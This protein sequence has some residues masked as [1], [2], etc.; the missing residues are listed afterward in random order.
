MPS[1]RPMRWLEAMSRHRATITAAPNFA[2]DLCVE[3]STPRSVRRSICRTGRRPCV[4]RSRCVARPW[5]RFA[6]AFAP[7]GFR[8]EAFHPVYGTGGGDAAGLG[9][10]RTPPYPVVR[11]MDRV[12][13]R[14]HRV[15]DVAPEHPSA[16]AFVGCGRPQGGQE[17][18]IVDP[19]T[20][21]PCGADEVG[22]IWV[23][24]P[25]VA[26][27]YWGRPEQTEEAFSASHLRRLGAARSSVPGTWDSF[28]RASCSSRDAARTSSS[29]AAATTTPRTSS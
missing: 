15:V 23:A 20:R 26:Q 8:P 16:A 14:E 29:S 6:D 24:G 7:A 22:E 10:R 5:R 19:E 17:V 28:A 13:L 4:A 21:R 25:S 2:Y 1:E 18:I 11:H 9:W 27:G 3:L 12:A